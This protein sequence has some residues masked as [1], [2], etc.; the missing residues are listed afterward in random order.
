MKNKIISFGTWGLVLFH[1]TLCGL[2]PL[3]ALAGILLGGPARLPFTKHFSHGAMLWLLVFSGIMIAL[4]FVSYI[5]GCRC[6]G[7]AKTAKLQKISL[8]IICVLYAAALAG[9]FAGAHI[10]G[11]M[12]CH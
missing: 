1:F 12:A 7:G 8:I 10:N 4:S 9:H 5:K 2:P 3:A 6:G 11:G